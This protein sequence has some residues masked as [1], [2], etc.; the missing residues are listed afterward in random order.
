MKPNREDSEGQ[1][2]ASEDAL[3]RAIISLHSATAP[4]NAAISFVICARRRSCRP[5]L[6]AGKSLNYLNKDSPIARFMTSLGS[7]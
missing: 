6:I 5:W 3:F 1:Q 2:T 4:L 7:V